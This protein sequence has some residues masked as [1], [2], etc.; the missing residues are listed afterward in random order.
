MTDEKDNV[1]CNECGSKLFSLDSI[2][3]GYC[4]ECASCKDVAR[5]SWED[6]GIVKFCYVC[7]IMLHARKSI[8]EGKCTE[9]RRI[10]KKI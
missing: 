1:K 5:K 6:K 3:A 8:D 7:G 2:A 4:A 9:C 10:S